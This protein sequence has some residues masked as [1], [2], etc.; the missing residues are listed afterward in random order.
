MPSVGAPFKYRVVAGGVTS[1]TYEIAVAVPPARDAHRRALHLSLGAAPRAAHGGPMAATSMLPRAPTSAVQVFTDRPAATGEMTLGSGQADPRLA[2]RQAD[3]AV[4][5]ADG[6]A[7][8]IPTGSCSADRDG[9][10]NPGDTEYFIRT[11]ED[12]PPD[13]RLPEAGDRSIRHPARGGGH[14]GTGRGRLRRRPPWI[15]SI[16]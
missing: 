10:G 5:V 15:L 9:V 11:L 14:R 4:R 7:A 2:G 3:R 6:Q 16:Q 8:T 13:V 12:R 1:P